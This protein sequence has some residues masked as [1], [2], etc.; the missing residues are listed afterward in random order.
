[1]PQAT[2]LRALG[3]SWKELVVRPMKARDCKVGMLICSPLYANLSTAFRT[4]GIQGFRT[5]GSNCAQ[6]A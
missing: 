6:H 2:K 5:I 4:G 3:P 1:M